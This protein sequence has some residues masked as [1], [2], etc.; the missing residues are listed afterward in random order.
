[1]NLIIGLFRSCFAGCSVCAKVVYGMIALQDVQ[2]ALRWFMGCGGGEDLEMLSWQI[3]W[4][5][6][7]EGGIWLPGN[8]IELHDEPRLV[9][10]L[11]YMTSSLPARTQAQQMYSMCIWR[12]V[13]VFHHNGMCSSGLGKHCLTV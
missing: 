12:R 11:Y 1:M 9:M 3:W 5:L 10:L 8:V 2:S 13:A 7:T 6:T 4:G